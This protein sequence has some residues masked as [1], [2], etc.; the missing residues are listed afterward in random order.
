MKDIA[1]IFRILLKRLCKNK[2]FLICIL[3]IPLLLFTVDLVEKSDETKISA[4]VYVEKHT[5]LND[6]LVENLLKSEGKVEFVLYTDLDKAQQDIVVGRI[7]C[8]YI[9]QEDLQNKIFEQR[10]K[11]AV[12]VYETAHSMLTKVI[13]EAFFYELFTLVSEEWFEG[14]I[15]NHEQ[16]MEIDQEKLL[17]DCRT[18]LKKNLDNGSTF[19]VEYHYVD[20]GKET[21]EVETKK[22]SFPIRGITAVIIFA[23]GF[24][25]IF[26]SVKDRREGPF[27]ILRKEKLVC[28]LDIVFPTF[29]ASII[30]LFV[31]YFTNIWCGAVEIYRMFLY[32]IFVVAW[33]MLVSFV[34]RKENILAAMFPLLLIYCFLIPPVF[35]D[36]GSFFPIISFLEKW[37]PVTY[38]L[39]WF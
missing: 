1:V 10:W 2:G 26:D 37:V 38:Y 39:R 32:S 13:N 7:E 5:K 14:Y 11:N 3:L 18:N 35:L 21:L 28:V 34:I 30:G 6:E 31:F 27:L 33:C 9:L 8:C 24:I 4:G 23:C 22:E 29:M 36:W 16:Y 17:K 20:I 25:G 12:L 15:A 19:Q